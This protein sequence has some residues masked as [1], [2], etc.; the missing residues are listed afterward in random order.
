M[1]II[2]VRHGESEHNASLTINKNSHLTGRG[3]KQAEALGD[4]LKKE[5]ISEFYSSKML[6]ADETAQIISKMIH[7][8]I[9]EQF[10]ELNE[11]ESKMLKS[12]LN[13]LLN[14][15]LKKLKKFLDLITKERKKDKTILIV[16]HGVTNRIIM[17]YLLQLPLKK[18]MLRFK[19]NNTAVNILSWDEDF[20]N[21]GL[22]SMN[23]TSHLSKNLRG[24]D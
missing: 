13:A 19:Q 12:R 17:G 20:K 3:R 9:K 15:R 18:Q 10:E 16:A 14:K 23:D 24:K 4:K 2:F 1:K 22:K 5:K 7:I 6:R 11:Y 8:P 21:W